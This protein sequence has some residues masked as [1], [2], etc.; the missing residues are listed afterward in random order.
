MIK[1]YLKVALRN[2]KKH[3]G[4][5]FINVVGLSIG[6]VCS[7]L[8]LLFVSNELSY[9]KFHENTDRIYR[10]AVRASIGD[11]KIH[12]TYSSSETFRKLFEE[13]PEPEFQRMSP[14][15]LISTM[16][17]LCPQRVFQPISM[18]PVGHQIVLLPIC[19]S[20]KA[21]HR[22]GLMKSLKTSQENIWVGKDM[23]LGW[24]KAITGSISS[25]P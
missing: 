16:I 19:S 21:L 2:I 11:T 13:F 5:F 4:F 25:S 22:S 7:I 6:I 15:I 24:H 20:M 1:N 10:L 18:I 3:K 9:D 17:F 12:Q 23:T 8:I 14:I